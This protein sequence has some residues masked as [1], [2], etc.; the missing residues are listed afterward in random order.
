[1]TASMDLLSHARGKAFIADA[2]Y[3]SNALITAVREKGLKAV[4]NP[5][6]GR[7]VHC[8]KLDKKLYSKRYRVEV[9]FFRLKRFRALATRYEKSAR[10]YLALLHLGCMMLR[11]ERIC[12]IVV[13][14]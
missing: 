5:N 14:Q 13:A 12:P 3:D 8:L 7:K 4:I 6:G 1:M 2:G 10:N 11:L 9:F